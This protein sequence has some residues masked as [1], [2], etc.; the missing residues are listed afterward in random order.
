MMF[1]TLIEKWHEIEKKRWERTADLQRRILDLKQ[2]AY[3]LE[4]VLASK[5]LDLDAEQEALR[6]EFTPQILAYGKTWKGLGGKISFRKG[7]VRV[8]YDWRK[9]DA[10]AAALEVVAPALAEQLRQAR[11]ESVGDVSW[12]IELDDNSGKSEEKK[13]EP[14]TGEIPF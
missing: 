14:G 10:I 2:Q 6:I 7:A 12:K 9:A 1:E 5:V 3:E 13:D 4:Q 11:S 8:S